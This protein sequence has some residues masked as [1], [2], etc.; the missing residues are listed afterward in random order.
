MKPVRRPDETVREFERRLRAAGLSR[1]AAKVE[2]GRPPR[3]G[4]LSLS[5]LP[6]RETRG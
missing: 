5:W 6:G 4:L 3:R 1:R 2:A